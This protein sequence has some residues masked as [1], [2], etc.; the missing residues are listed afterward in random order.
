MADTSAV[1]DPRATEDAGRIP[2]LAVCSLVFG[3]VW[4]L[5]FGSLIAVITGHLARARIRE[6][7]GV[8]RGMG[9]AMAG[10]VLG[11]M[12]LVI[13]VLSVVAYLYPPARS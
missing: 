8:L 6:K 5:G 3:I 2:T 12:G 13:V 4:L 9:L 7:P 11:Y 1:D 10:L